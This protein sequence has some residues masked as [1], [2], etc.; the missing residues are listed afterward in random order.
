MPSIH[1]WVTVAGDGG[2]VLLELVGRAEGVAGAGHEQARHLEGGEVLDAQAVGPARRVQRVADRARGPAAGSPS[3]TA[4]EQMRPPIDRPP[5]TIRSGATPAAL[6]ERPGLLH[7]AGEQLRRAVGRLAALAAVGEVA[8]LHR[9]RRERLL[10][11]D[12]ARAGR[13]SCPRP[14][15][16]GAPPGLRRRGLT[17][18]SRIRRASVRSAIRWAA[19]SVSP[20]WSGWASR[21]RSRNWRCT[22]CR[23][24]HADGR[25]RRRGRARRAPTAPGRGTRPWTSRGRGRARTGG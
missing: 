8:P 12:E 22:S 5:R 2:G 14:G 7:H 1:T 21:S 6:G 17:S 13:P 3:A 9:Q 24:G 18:A 23:G 15:T 20:P 16:A 19:S 4:M 10:D 11:G 25:C